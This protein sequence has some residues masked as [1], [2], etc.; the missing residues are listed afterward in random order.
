MSAK[1]NSKFCPDGSLL[2]PVE[3][4]V[5][6]EKKLY[7]VS[8]D[9]NYKELAKSN[10]KIQIYN[11]YPTV[12]NTALV[13]E[14]WDDMKYDMTYPRIMSRCRNKQCPSRGGLAE[15]VKIASN[16]KV[17]ITYLCTV[18]NYRWGAKI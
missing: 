15:I 11:R 7:M 8:N 9:S 12:P 2:H 13:K 17:E 6:G 10:V 4:E 3:I 18:C 5:D 14:R 1:E 16:R